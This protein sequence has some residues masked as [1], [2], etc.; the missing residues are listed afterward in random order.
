MGS[1]KANPLQ[2]LDFIEHVQQIGKIHTVLTAIGIDVLTQQHDFLHAVSCKL[3]NF[4]ENFRRLS[5]PLPA[6]GIRHDA[7]SAEIVAAKHDVDQRFTFVKPLRW[8]SFY[9]LAA[10]WPDFHLLLFLPESIVNQLRKLMNIVSSED[11]IHPRIFCLNRID[12]VLLLHHT[13]TDADQ[14]IGIVLFS[15]FQLSQCA[16]KPLIR[17]IPYTA[18]IDNGN[19]SVFSL[20][21]RRKAFF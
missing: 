18:G 9:D 8:Q 17:I 19:V 20:P 15:V 1:H 21:H 14:E 2:S 3:P 13:A 11:D 4:T 7:V 10:V 12:D 16:E 5:A 6:P